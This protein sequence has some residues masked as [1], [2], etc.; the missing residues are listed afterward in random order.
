MSPGL[1]SMEPK[2]RFWPHVLPGSEPEPEKRV[3]G[4]LV[5]PCD[6]R[7]CLASARHIFWSTALRVQPAPLGRVWVS[8]GMSKAFSQPGLS[9]C[10]ES[11]I[12]QRSRM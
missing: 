6:R 10:E 12:A 7:P 3:T 9:P 8:T 11:S 1:W 2:D 4:H 5:H